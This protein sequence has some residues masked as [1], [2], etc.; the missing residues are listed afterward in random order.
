MFN[1]LSVVATVL[2]WST[3]VCN[4]I[5]ILLQIVAQAWAVRTLCLGKQLPTNRSSTT[6]SASTDSASDGTGS[7][8]QPLLESEAAALF[9]EGYEED[10][11]E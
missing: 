9:G 7:A 10:E 1:G 3:V 2:V 8:C 6:E 4:G 11:E 5:A